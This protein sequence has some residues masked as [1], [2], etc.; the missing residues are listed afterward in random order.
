MA[1]QEIGDVEICGFAACVPSKIEENEHLDLFQNF[2][3]YEKFALHTG[4]ERRRVASE[5][6]TASDLCLE[7]AEKLLKELGWEKED[8]DCLLF[9]SHSPD[10]RYP[11]TA[12]ILQGKLGLSQECMSFDISLGCSGWVYGLTVAG[13]LVTSGK[14]KK[15]LLLTGDVTTSSKSK[16]DRT[17]YPLFGDA[18]SAVDSG[19]DS[20][21]GVSWSGM[22]ECTSLTLSR[23]EMYPGNT[24]I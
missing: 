3:Q 6:Q 2:G 5:G 10:Y 4:G 18:G 17:T 13:S 11:A 12:C 21:G 22:P 7:A 8:V 14:F 1:I 23:F 16:K 15:A 20:P 24:R 9:V 19:S